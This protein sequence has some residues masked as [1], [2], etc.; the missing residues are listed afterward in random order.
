MSAFGAADKD[1][2]DD[3]A[4]FD[5]GNLGGGYGGMNAESEESE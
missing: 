4:N 3:R 2:T 5:V 1:V